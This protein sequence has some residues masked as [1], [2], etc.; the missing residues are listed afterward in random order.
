[1]K[2]CTN[3]Q[4]SQPSRLRLQKA[5]QISDTSRHYHHYH[6]T[7]LALISLTLS[8]HPSLSSISPG[9]LQGYNLY[10]LRAVV[11]GFNLV[12]LP[13][14]VHLKGFTVWQYWSMAVR[15]GLTKNLS[16][17]ILLP[18]SVKLKCLRKR[19]ENSEKEFLTIVKT[20]NGKML[21]G[22]GG[23]QVGYK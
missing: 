21:T 13:L 2:F 1:M 22:N 18:R 17:Q 11:Y 19:I 14:H 6:G 7:L 8:R 3:L 9:G 16:S 20:E 12:V 5:S 10:R 15:E 4:I 23:D